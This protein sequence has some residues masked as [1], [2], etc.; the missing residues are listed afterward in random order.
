[1]AREIVEVDRLAT[2]DLSCASNQAVALGALHYA[3]RRF[4][5]APSRVRELRRAKLGTPEV[6]RTG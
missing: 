2:L 4:G 1:M 5:D 3:L 6:A